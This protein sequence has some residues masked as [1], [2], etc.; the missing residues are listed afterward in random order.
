M[1]QACEQAGLE[2]PLLEEIGVHFRVTIF[3]VRRSTPAIDDLDQ[4]ILDVL[5]ES[6]GLTTA[7]IAQRIGRSV[8]A[9]RSRLASLVE[10]GFVAEIGTSPHDPRRKYLLARRTGREG[11]ES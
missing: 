4:V 5:A 8:R 1:I 2:S 6:P 9:T 11:R 7:Q 3:A 10:R